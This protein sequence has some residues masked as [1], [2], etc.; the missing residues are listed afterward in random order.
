MRVFRRRV[1]RKV[2][3]PKRDEVTG[4]GEDYIMRSF[5]VCVPH[6]LLLGRS[7]H[8]LD[9]WDMWLIW[10]TGVLLT[11]FWWGN[12]RQRDHLEDLGIR[13]WGGGVML[14]WI[15]E[16]WGG[17]AWAELIWLRIGTGGQLL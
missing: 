7:D 8:V 9:G 1:L 6:Q 13:V 10:E 16:K 14:K 17:E 12:L 3:Q 4:S 15:F 11:G 5:I 2:F